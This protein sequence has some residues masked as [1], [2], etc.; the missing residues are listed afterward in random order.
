ML[1]Q[2]FC[3]GHHVGVVARR[4]VPLQD[5]ELRVVAR[6]STLTIAKTLTN[7]K[8]TANVRGQ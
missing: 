1:E 7:L 3:V 5:R 6:T 8:N 4:V 2:F